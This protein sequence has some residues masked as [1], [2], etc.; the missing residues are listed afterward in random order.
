MTTTLGDTSSD[1][2][3]VPEEVEEELGPQV[4]KLKHPVKDMGELIT[5]VTLEPPTN[6]QYRKYKTPFLIIDGVPDILP[7]RVAQYIPGCC[8]LAE[9]TVNKMSPADILIIG[10]SLSAFF[11]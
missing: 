11:A 8:N 3:N 6:K 9:S 5:E 7:E 4:I 1:E 2:E 10:L